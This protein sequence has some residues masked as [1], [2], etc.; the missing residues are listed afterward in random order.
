MIDL[1]E[2]PLEEIISTCEKY[3]ARMTK[4]GMT[5]ELEIGI[6]GGEEDGVDNSGVSAEKLYTHPEDV[7]QVYSRLSPISHR[8]TIAAAF[9]NVHGVYKPGNVVLKPELLG[10]CQKYVVEKLGAD[11]K[12][13]KPVFFVFHG[14]SG[15][16]KKDIKTALTNGVVKMNVD[17][18]TQWAYWEGLLNFYKKNEGFLQGQ[19]GNPDGADKPNKKFYDPR[20][21][22]RKCEESMIARITEAFEDL[23]C[24]GKL[25]D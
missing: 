18:D 17:T 22:L 4:M 7:W 13:D 19:I 2:E 5:L 14:G 12:D 25:S 15:S 3:L 6:T 11:C 8:F 9:G 16:E 1:S 20:V 21:W 23:D 24:K 10:D